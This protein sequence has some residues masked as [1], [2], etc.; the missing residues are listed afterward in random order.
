M[1]SSTSY[2][3]MSSLFSSDSEELAFFKVTFKTIGFLIYFLQPF[4]FYFLLDDST[5]LLLSESD[6][7][8]KSIF[9]KIFLL[10]KNNSKKVYH[11][12]CI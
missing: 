11:Y 6:F 4:L 2:S 1:I 9:L 5:D 8:S 12:V 10:I 7:V 3:G